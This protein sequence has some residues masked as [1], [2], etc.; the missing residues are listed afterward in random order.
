MAM[1]PLHV[2]LNSGS[3]AWLKG[4]VASSSS[5]WLQSRV[6][7]SN[8]ACLQGN[9][10]QGL[11]GSRV[12]WLKCR[13]AYSRAKDGQCFARRC[14]AQASRC[15]IR[16][17]HTH[18]TSTLLCSAGV[19]IHSD[20][21]D[22]RDRHDRLSQYQQVMAVLTGPVKKNTPVRPDRQDRLFWPDRAVGVPL[23]P[24]LG[25]PPS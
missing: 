17:G 15:D 20:R 11:R 22:F 18:S 12:T 10:A 1:L 24:L 13:V 14:A 19:S 4:R 16:E 23:C 8:S 5:A 7:S 25:G 9:M 2:W 6:A 3:A 21:T